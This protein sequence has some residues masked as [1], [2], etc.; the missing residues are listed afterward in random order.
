[1][2][3]A[4]L[5]TAAVGADPG[6]IARLAVGKFFGIVGAISPGQTSKLLL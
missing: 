6:L 2:R 1:V 3:A 5:G 4:L